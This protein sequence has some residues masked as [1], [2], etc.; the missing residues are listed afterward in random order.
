MPGRPLCT[1]AHAIALGYASAA[2][3]RRRAV[4]RETLQALT[5]VSPQAC[6][7]QAVANLQGWADARGASSAEGA[8]HADEDGT[9]S[10]LRVRV[11]PA[12]WGEVAQAMTIAHGTCCAVL[13]MAHPQVPGGAYVEGAA[14]QEENLMRRT[15]AHFH[16]L[17]E[18]IDPA[19]GRYRAEMTDL[20]T[21]GPGQVYLDAVYPR[22]CVRGPEDASQADLGYRWLSPQEIFPF[23]EL[24]AAAQDLRDGAAF[25]AVQARRRIAAQL[26]TLRAHGIRHAVLG[27]FGCGAF[28]N[29]AEQVAAI[30]RDEIAARA[31]SFSA[32]DFAIRDAGA[33]GRGRDTFAAFARVL[34]GHRA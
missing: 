22:V 1:A 21:A 11:L 3:A 27:A 8:R 30:Y 15:D 33:A 34:A 19:S 6:L 13:N 20:L 2:C 26:D 31:A 14:A 10:S 32:I 25:D 12:D 17:D 4:L 16:L 5:E 18:H 7:E 28:G 9:P 29:P 23:F 24:R